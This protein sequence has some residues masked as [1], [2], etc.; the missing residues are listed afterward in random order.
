M[1]EFA[2]D[3]MLAVLGASVGLAGL[4]LVFSGFVLSQASSFPSTTDDD[5]IERF[6]KAGRFGVWPF[7]LAIVIALL[8]VTWFIAP[9]HGI[10]LSALI[11]FVALLVATGIYGAVLFWSYL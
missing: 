3:V 6:E 7:L 10:Y 8:S 2:K 1:P 11:G 9:C 4:L 5:V